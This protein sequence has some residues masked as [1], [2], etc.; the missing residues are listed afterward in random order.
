M[1]L[2]D[3]SQLLYDRDIYRARD[4]TTGEAKPVNRGTLQKWLEQARAAGLL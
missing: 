4:R 1:S 3:F 2:A